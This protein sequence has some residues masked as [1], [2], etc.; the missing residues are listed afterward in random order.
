MTEKYGEDVYFAYAKEALDYYHS[1]MR[2]YIDS[3]GHMSVWAGDPSEKVLEEAHKFSLAATGL[4]YP[5]VLCEQIDIYNKRAYE[6]NRS[7]HHCR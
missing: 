4:L 3:I 2:K 6:R 1:F 7:P 5:P